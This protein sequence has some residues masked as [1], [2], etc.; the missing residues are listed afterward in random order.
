MEVTVD[1]VER[2]TRKSL[3]ETGAAD[4]PTKEVEEGWRLRIKLG[5]HITEVKR[6][7]WRKEGVFSGSKGRETANESDPVLT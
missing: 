6:R 1:C 5:D 4:A 7:W 2:S 3:S